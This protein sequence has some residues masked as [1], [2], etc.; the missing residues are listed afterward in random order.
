MHGSGTRLFV[1][2]IAFGATED[3]LS[4][5]FSEVGPIRNCRIIYDRES[6]RSKGF[7]FVEMASETNAKVAVMQI[8]GRILHNRTLNVDYARPR[9][10]SMMPQQDVDT[11]A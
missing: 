9:P 10:D 8:N 11:L 5:M 4:K 6:G 3:D 1:S 7:G 2:N